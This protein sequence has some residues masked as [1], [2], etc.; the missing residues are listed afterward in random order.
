MCVSS[1]TTR[2]CTNRTRKNFINNSL[3]A[4]TLRWSNGKGDYV[5]LNDVDEF[6]GAFYL[7][8]SL[9]RRNTHQT[10]HRVVW[11]TKKRNKSKPIEGNC[12]IGE[13]YQSPMEGSEVVSLVSFHD[14]ISVSFSSPVL[15][16]EITFPTDEATAFST[17]TRREYVLLAFKCHLSLKHY[18]FSQQQA[19]GR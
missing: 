4:H 19:Y 5:F 17:T 2:R 9:L 14:L 13:V 6:W 10:E 16:Y 11:W 12:C 1:S 15:K 7:V 18:C 3:E 8:S